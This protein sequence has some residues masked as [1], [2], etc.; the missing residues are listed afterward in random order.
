MADTLSL[1]FNADLVALDTGDMGSVYINPDADSASVDVLRHERRPS[2]CPGRR[3]PTPKRRTWR[4]PACRATPRRSRTGCR[5][6]RRA[7]IS[8]EYVLFRRV[9]ARTPRVSRGA[10]STTRATRSSTT[11]RATTLGNLTEIRPS[12]LPII[13]TAAIHGAQTDT[14]HSALTD[15]IREVRVQFT[16]VFH[17]PRL[18]RRRRSASSSATIHLMNAGLLHH[19]TCGQPPLAPA[20]VTASVTAANGTTIPQTYV[21][22]AWT[23]SVDDGA[24]EK[25]V[26]PIRAVPSAVERH[27]V[28]RA[29][30]QRARRRGHLLVPRHGRAERPDVDLRGG[31]GGLHPGDVADD[32]IVVRLSFHRGTDSMKLLH[33]SQTQTARA[34]AGARPCSCR[35]SS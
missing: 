24:G 18:Q 25:D 12:A 29:V 14:G 8:N 3:R 30:R 22:I 4:A 31:R 35:C 26:D 16:T 20:S 6:I 13:H 11:S 17:D 32:R 9:N 19:S 27:D 5:R 15:S 21:T 33:R 34:P 10:S 23:K 1:T 2:R 7:R 28:R